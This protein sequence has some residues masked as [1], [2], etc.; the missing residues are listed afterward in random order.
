M[1]RQTLRSALEFRRIV[2]LEKHKYPLAWSLDLEP[3][4]PPSN[5]VAWRVRRVSRGWKG[6]DVVTVENPHIVG[7]V[8]LVMQL[9]ATRD[10]LSRAVGGVSGLYRLDPIDEHGRV[11]AWPPSYIPIDSP[12]DMYSSADP[13]QPGYRSASFPP[14]TLRRR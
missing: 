14:C 3:I 12:R 5:A 2:A 6:F 9:R 13:N 11:L 1:S 10:D 8:P 7:W 4:E